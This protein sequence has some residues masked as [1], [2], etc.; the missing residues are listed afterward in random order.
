MN[1]A[2]F[3]A[4]KAD[5][6]EMIR[7]ALT[8]VNPY[9]ST[10]SNLSINGNV[11][12]VAGKSVDLG[13]VKHLYVIGIGKAAV[14]MTQAAVDCFDAMVTRGIALTKQGQTGRVDHPRVTT[15][16]S[17]HPVPDES[18]V[19]GA[20]AI[21]ELLKQAGQEDFVLFLISG[22]ASALCTRPLLPLTEWQL[23]SKQLLASGCPIQAFN[24]VRKQLDEVKGG[25]LGRLA[26]PAQMATLVLSD[27]IGNP[28]GMIGSG[29]TVS[30]DQRPTDALAI[31]KRYG[32]SHV[33]AEDVLQRLDGDVGAL[34]FESPYQ[35]IGD[36]LLA[37]E[38]AKVHAESL[39]Y[40]AKLVTTSLDG[41][42]RDV[43]KWAAELAQQL[44]PGECLIAGGETTV[45]LRGDGLGGR[46]Q[47][48]ALAAAIELDGSTDVVVATYATDGDDGPT[49]AAGAIVDGR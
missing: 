1:D 23:L 46:N 38:S 49:P 12:R 10:I 15:L 29:P 44:A 5:I 34:G 9:K 28:I 32:I 8:A 48:L 39:G 24:T 7:A 25:G 19:D 3:I 26:L 13:S 27:V 21:I 33:A 14:P 16:L 30:S 22:G 31:L 4:V 6:M 42:A 37:A 41:E 2:K 36:I 17:A 11:L 43:G 40:S 35:I 45:T 20:T 18:S 47:E